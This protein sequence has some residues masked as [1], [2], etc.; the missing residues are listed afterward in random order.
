MGVTHWINDVGFVESLEGSVTARSQ[1][2]GLVGGH[3]RPG[4]DHPPARPVP[5]DLRLVPDMKA[6]KRS[7]KLK[8]PRQQ[9]LATST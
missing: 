8:T 6:S 3:R 5:S 9:G 4:K 2:R 1:H 7:G